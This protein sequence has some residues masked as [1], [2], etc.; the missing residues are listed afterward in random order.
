[1]SKLILAKTENLQLN[2]PDLKTGEICEAIV[3]MRKVMCIEVLDN[4]KHTQI[5]E[6][7]EDLLESEV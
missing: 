4:N 2:Y 1:M 3:V 6:M 7:R 5:I